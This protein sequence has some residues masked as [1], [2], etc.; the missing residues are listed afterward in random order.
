MFRTALMIFAVVLLIAA[1]RDARAQIDPVKRQLIQFGYTAPTEGRAPLSGYAFFYANDPDFFRTNYACRL[2]LAPVYLDTELG[3]RGVLGPYTDLGFGLA[4]GGFAD[5]Y[6]EIRA[7]RYLPAESFSGHNVEG[8][9]SLY[10]RL[11]PGALIP[12]NLVLR[13]AVHHGFYER[14]DD[15]AADFALPPEH[16]SFLLRAGFRWGGQE[17]LLF[18][19]LGM[20]LSAWYEA[21]CRDRTA[22]Y[23]FGDRQL[24]AVSHLFWGQALLAY[25]LPGN[26][27]YFRVSVTAGASLDADRLN[28]YRLGALLPL[29]SEFPL[30]LPGYFY[31][32]LSAQRFALLGASY[33]FPLDRR[34]RWNVNLTAATAYVDY[35]PGL[36]QPGGRWHSGVAAGMLFRL[37]GDTFKVLLV[38]AY[39]VDAMRGS[40]RGAQ[41]VSVLM[42]LDLEQAR[43]ALLNP[44]KPG[45]WRGWERIFGG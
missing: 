10:H 18:P 4:G 19:S 44:D 32:E 20:E 40:G 24:R 15:T 8:S 27:Q 41:S 14:D 35:L 26:G 11:N 22:L 38:Y 33:L 9:V 2:A 7:G 43:G 42:Q 21:E 3:I 31:Q 34:Q 36:E 29:A 12:L 1:G 37:P 6:A 30:A 16:S 39:G 13:G 23:G 28:S 17:P 25:T 45:R 5:S